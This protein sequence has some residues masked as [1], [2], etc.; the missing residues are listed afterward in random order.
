MESYNRVAKSRENAIIFANFF[1]PS[2]TTKSV[3]VESYI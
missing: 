2:V 1:K 3:F